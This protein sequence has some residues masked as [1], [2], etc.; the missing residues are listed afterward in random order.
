MKRLIS[1]P[2]QPVQFQHGRL[3]GATKRQVLDCKRI[4]MLNPGLV[5]MRRIESNTVKF[6]SVQIEYPGDSGDISMGEDGNLP[7]NIS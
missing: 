6:L 4:Y 7:I 3:P 1:V 2:A 5:L